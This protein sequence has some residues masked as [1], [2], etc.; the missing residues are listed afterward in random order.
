MSLI[1]YS[2]EYPIPTSISLLYKKLS[3]ASGLSEWFAENVNVKNKI[4][5]FYWEGSEEKAKILKQEK[6]KFIRYQWLHDDNEYEEERYFEFRIQVDDMTKDIALIVTD[7]AEDNDL[8]Q[9]GILLWNKEI[10]NLKNAL[11]I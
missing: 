10:E 4:L 1:K 8:K 7:F 2:L 6:E 5:T 9:E 11:R 3:T